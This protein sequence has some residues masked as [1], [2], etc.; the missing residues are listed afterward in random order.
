MKTKEHTLSSDFLDLL[1]S[2]NL[3]PLISKPTR[4]TTTT[5]TLI[6]NIFTNDFKDT[7]NHHQGI[8]YNDISD[9]FP[10]FHI[11]KAHEIN[12]SKDKYIWKRIISPEKI[13]NFQNELKNINWEDVLSYTEP[14]ATYSLFHNKFMYIY[15]KVFPMINAKLNPIQLG[16]LG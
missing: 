1:Y 8:L 9:H 2:Y 12:S 5:A 3:F 16:F 15:E 6:D 14:Q 4:V 13:D 7:H 11:D 10:I